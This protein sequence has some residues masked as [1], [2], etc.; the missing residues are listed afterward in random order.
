[1]RLHEEGQEWRVDL[2]P[3]R[4]RPGALLTTRRASSRRRRQR[5]SS[6][7]RPT[8][9]FRPE[10]PKYVRLVR[11]LVG[12]PHQLNQP[13]RTV[14]N[15][16]ANVNDPTSMSTTSHSLVVRLH[17]D[18]PQEPSRAGSSQTPEKA[19]PGTD[20]GE[21][22][23]GSGQRATWGTGFMPV[24]VAAA[25]VITMIGVLNFEGSAKCGW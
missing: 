14:P 18:L 24:I 12:G 6:Y 4:S 7:D 13:C 2:G 22:R 1:M 15:H 8:H 21:T 10:E 3:K 19:S 17:R 11:S 9:F 25:A 5:Q 16:V 20:P 23:H